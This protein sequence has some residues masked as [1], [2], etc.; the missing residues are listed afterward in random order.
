MLKVGVARWRRCIA[1]K[2]GFY[3]FLLPLTEI[4]CCISISRINSIKI[5]PMIFFYFVEV[6]VIMSLIRIMTKPFCTM[7]PYLHLLTKMI[8][9]SSFIAV[10]RSSSVLALSSRRSRCR[11]WT[12]HWRHHRVHGLS[13]ALP[14]QQTL[15]LDGLYE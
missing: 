10:A 13:Q 7:F 6:C 1:F 11:V 14:I 9:Q 15:R 8:H 2:F 12:G 5:V 4:L 3:V